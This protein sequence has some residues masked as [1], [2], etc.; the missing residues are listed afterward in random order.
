MG[1]GGVTKE[2]FL[3]HLETWRYKI[4]ITWVYIAKKGL[5]PIIYNIRCQF[6]QHFM[7]I[8]LPIF[9]HQ[10]FSNPKHNFVIFGSKI[11][12]QKC[13]HKLLMKLTPGV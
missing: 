9:W 13:T 6:H 12:Y 2:I 3:E 11:S 1:A 4:Y 7:R 10:K 5:E 8:F